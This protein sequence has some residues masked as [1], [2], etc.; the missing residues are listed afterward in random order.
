MSKMIKLSEVAELTVGYV[1][2][3]G[4]EYSKH[5]VT[6]LRSLNIKP[7]TFDLSDIRFIPSEFNE[8]IKKSELHKDDVVIVRTGLPGTSAVIPEELDGSNCADLV[9]VRPDQ[10]LVNPYYLCAFIN[11]WG[12]TQ[13]SNAKVGAIQKHFNVTSAGEMLIPIID[14]EKQNAIA[15]LLQDINS[16]IINNIAICTELEEMSKS[17]YDYWFVQFDFPDKNGK[18]YKSSGGEMI[19]N[20][21]LKRYIPK[22]WKAGNLYDI[23]DY[24]NGL[25]CQKYRPVDEANKLPVIKIGEMHNGFGEDVE[26]ARSDVDGKHIIQNGDILF[27][28]SASLEVMLWNKGTG[29]LNQHIFKVVPKMNKFYVLQQLFAYVI[30]FVRMAEARKTTMGHITTDHLKQSRIIIPPHGIAD[31]FGDNVNDVYEKTIVYAEENQQLTSLRNYILPML[32][33]GQLTIRDV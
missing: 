17:L 9:I 2:P 10:S 30:N 27:S 20:E 24:V 12:K 13:I 21:E 4:K 26:W 15:K 23:A 28:W 16:K 1:G 25:A 6:F 8:K 31:A 32:M 29:I 33:N 5:G 22:G 7:F 11:S 19:W 3:M 18:P 14:I